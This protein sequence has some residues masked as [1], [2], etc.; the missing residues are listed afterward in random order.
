MRSTSRAGSPLL[1]GLAP[2]GVFRASP[3]ARRAVGSYPT[4]SPLPAEPAFRRRLAGLP[5]RCHRASLHRRSILCGTFR[6]T[7]A[8]ASACVLSARRKR[9]AAPPKMHRLKSVLL[10]PLALPGAFTLRP[11]AEGLPLPPKAPYPIARVGVRTF[12]PFTLRDRQ[13]PKGLPFPWHHSEQASDHPAHPLL[14]LYRG[15]VRLVG[16]LATDSDT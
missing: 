1:F 16:F 2:R 6:D 9:S 11:V 10:R 7:V 13:G 8:Q 15:F 3:V 14:S 5:A 4:F 12:L